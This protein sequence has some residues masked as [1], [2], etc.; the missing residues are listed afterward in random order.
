MKNG[1]ISTSMQSSI[2]EY[3]ADHRR[4]MLS[5]LKILVLIQS[6]TY[7]IAGVNNVAQ[8]LGDTF[9][10]MGLDVTTVTPEACGNMLV[11]SSPAAGSGKNLLLTGHMDT[12]FP[13]DTAFNWWREDEKHVYGPGVIDMKGGLVAGIYAL[14][15]LAHVGM[16]T[17]IPVRFVCNSDEEIGS[18]HS[19]SLIAAEA[20]QSA[21][22]FVLECG[23]LS[24]EVVTG[25]KG[26]LGIRLEVFG[27]A[28][29]AAFITKN[30]ASAIL[31]LAHKIVALE[32]LN[33]QREGLTVN[34]GRI[35]GGI[36]ANSVAEYARAETDVRFITEAE[37]DFFEERMAEIAEDGR[38]S[39]TSVRVERVSFR[40]PMEQVGANRA[41][42]GVIANQAGVLH[43]PL[44]E[45]LRPGVSDANFIAREKIPVIDGLGPIGGQDHSDREFMIKESL[46]QRCQLLALSIGE[47][48]QRYQAGNLFDTSFS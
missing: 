13:E 11:V 32:A 35:E 28:G 6:G 2:I 30:K 46:I 40:P 16:L 29:H 22:A 42:F 38:I 41:L 19:Q 7:N 48:W 37:A 44:E 1:S 8:V 47:A 33:G 43:L 39:E 36:G 23:G 24:G 31:A 3:I 26:R 17:A 9:S 34:I 18:P 20:R 14:K 21:M 25:R 45:E 4:E 12:V 15:A 10:E 27:K 5:L